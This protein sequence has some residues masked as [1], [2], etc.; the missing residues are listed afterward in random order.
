MKTKNICII[1]SLLS[2]IVFTSCSK[3]EGCTD[4]LAINYSADAD[5]DDGS[6]QYLTPT[7]SAATTLL[8]ILPIIS[9]EPMCRHLILTS[10]ILSMKM[11]IP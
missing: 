7:P 5:K 4:P 9:T 3:K 6:C 8:L 1:V 2:V 11:T 10:S